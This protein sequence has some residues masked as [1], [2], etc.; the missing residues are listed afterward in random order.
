M[1]NNGQ[2]KLKGMLANQEHKNYI[3]NI[4]V[5]NAKKLYLQNYR[6]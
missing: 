3:K 4:L 5:Q 1:Q 6:N 2:R